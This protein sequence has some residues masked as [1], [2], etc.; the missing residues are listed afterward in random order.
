MLTSVKNKE[1][2]P[3]PEYSTLDNIRIKADVDIFPATPYLNDN[4]YGESQLYYSDMEGI[5]SEENSY[6]WP[7]AAEYSIDRIFE[8]TFTSKLFRL[9]PSN[10]PCKY[11]I[12]KVLC[13]DVDVSSKVNA[14]NS[15]CEKD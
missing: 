7:Y 15:I 2:K 9:D 10:K 3:L 5:L 1:W 11:K 8:N 12:I 4:Y 6:R 13:D 14:I